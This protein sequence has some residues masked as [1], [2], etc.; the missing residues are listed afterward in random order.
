MKK[1][2]AN[3]SDHPQDGV[4]LFDN[5]DL[6][7]NVPIHVKTWLTVD[8][9]AKLFPIPK[10]SLYKYKATG[11]PMRKLDGKLVCKREDIEEYLELRSSLGAS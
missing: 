8:E 6:S 11:F 9:A 5:F 7:K 1:N 4:T 3:M 2:S 10:N